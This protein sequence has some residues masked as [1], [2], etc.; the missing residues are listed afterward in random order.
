M[1]ST[2]WLDEVKWNDD[3]LVTAIAQ[4]HQSGDVLMLAWMNRESLK[5]TLEEGI[6]VYWSRSRGKLWRKG[7]SS[8]HTQRLVECRLDCDGDA[9]LLKVEQMGGIACHTGRQSCF[10][11]RLEGD[12]VEMASWKAADPVLQDPK[13][14]YNN[15]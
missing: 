7:E 14:I 15:Q 13:S 8:G 5:L 3:G 11:K 4:D 6:G 9:I 10:Y 2:H 1:A 12:D